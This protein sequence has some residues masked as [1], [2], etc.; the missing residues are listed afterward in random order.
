MD[1]C[2][3]LSRYCGENQAVRR[4]Q[5]GVPQAINQGGIAFGPSSGEWKHNGLLLQDSDMRHLAGIAPLDRSQINL[6]TY[7]PA[8][9]ARP[10]KP[11]KKR[12]HRSKQ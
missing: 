10:A 6:M 3:N 2:S 5:L 9:D 7:G 8:P 1:C 4:H 11:S 12:R